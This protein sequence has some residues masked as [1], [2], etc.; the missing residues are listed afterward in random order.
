MAD[1]LEIAIGEK[2]RL[3]FEITDDLPTML[4]DMALFEQSILNLCFNAAAAMP[5]G[6]IVLLRCSRSGAGVSVSVTDN[7]IDM[8]PEAIDKTFEPYFTTRD[9]EGGAG[10]GLAMVYGFVR[11]SGC[12]AALPRCRPRERLLNF[13]S[14]REIRPARLEPNRTGDPSI[15]PILVPS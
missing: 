2:C 15:L 12:D 14:R 8:S 3:V 1:V 7:G 10:L 13:R 9:A 11:Q 6:G 4:I 5:E